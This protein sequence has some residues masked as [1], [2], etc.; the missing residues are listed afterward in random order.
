MSQAVHDAVLVVCVWVALAQWAKWELIEREGHQPTRKGRHQA[1]HSG[2]PRPFAG[3]TQKPIC[4]EC[5]KEEEQ[6]KGGVEAPPKMVSGRG[7]PAAV[8]TSQQFGACFLAPAPGY[9]PSYAGHGLAQ[10]L[11]G[12][13]SGH[14]CTCARCKCGGRSHRPHLDAARG[15]ALSGASCAPSAACGITGQARDRLVNAACWPKSGPTGT[16]AGRK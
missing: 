4:P 3:L 2:E 12:V 6:G 1:H 8:D 7:R 10:A 13:H 11:A 16:S 9:T 5:E 14:T 15:L